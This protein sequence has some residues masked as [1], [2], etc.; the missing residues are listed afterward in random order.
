MKKIT[1]ILTMTLLLAF[2]TGLTSCQGLI[3][4]VV[5]GHAD[6][7]SQPDPALPPQTFDASTIP[8]T[9]EANV[10]NTSV[11]FQLTGVL[12]KSYST[13]EYSLDGGTT[14]TAL[15]SADQEILLAAVGNK[16]MFRGTNASYNGD[17]KFVVTTAAKAGTRGMTRASSSEALC[18]IYGNVMSLIK[19]TGF[20]ELKELTTANAGAFKEMFAD[21]PINVP[22]AKEQALVLPATTL[23]SACYDNM[24]SGCENLTQTP[25][26][27]AETLAD[28][29]YNGMFAGCKNLTETT[30]L[31]ATE[32]AEGCYSSMF[33]G[34]E[35]LTQTPELPAETLADNCYNSMF[36]GCTSLTEVSELPAKKLSEGCYNSMFSGCESLTE[37]PVLPAETLVTDCYSGMFEKCENLT[38]VTV[39][40]TGV[41]EGVT[42]SDCISNWLNGAG[43]KTEEAPVIITAEETKISASEMVAVS[44]D[45]ATT[46]E[47]KTEAETVK[48]AI[49]ISNTKLSL[50][51][52]EEMTLTAKLSPAPEG[53]VGEISWKSSNEQ[54][55]TVENGKVTAVGFGEA[56]ITA[57]YGEGDDAISAE[58]K[59]SVAK[60]SIE[61]SQSH[62]EIYMEGKFTLTANSTPS[63]YGKIE[64]VSDDEDIAKVDQSGNVT[65][66]LNPGKTNIVAL[67]K[68]NDEIMAYATC[69]LIVARMRIVTDGPI[70]MTIGQERQLQYEL[71]PSDGKGTISWES[72][73]EG[74]ITVDQTGKVTA[75][76]VGDAHIAVN[77]SYNGMGVAR[78]NAPKITVVAAK[79]ENTL[80]APDKFVDGGNPLAN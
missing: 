25:A 5:G 8:L 66:F 43:T 45:A 27:P 33:A 11:K 78:G 46:W 2:V 63:D 64:W 51:P 38:G 20:A 17:G 57:T 4:A 24:F 69:E 29:C 37:A 52:K 75:V 6:N 26:L 31:P 13:V 53:N 1:S 65:T 48:Y 72:D 14:W 40:A 76:G 74:V 67:L 10:A 35:S 19:S 39:L 59:V 9:F 50:N 73:N 42:A 58:C 80:Q 54:V 55:A 28:N 21:Q 16:V 34:C 60:L 3:D 15:T 41:A 68:Y 12:A 23:V 30:E 22:S 18:L 61:I 32:L 44:G 56:T 7:P 71:T 77:Y 36:S 62:Y 49:I 70:E 47:V 79:E